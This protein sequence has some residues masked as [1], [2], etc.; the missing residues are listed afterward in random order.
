[1]PIPDFQ[2]IML[3]FLELLQDGKERTVR[4]VTESL[5]VHFR[6]TDEE[7][8]EHLPSGQ[9]LFPNRVAW[10]KTHLKHAGLIDSPAWGKV[11][12]TEEGRKTLAQKPAMVNM[13]MLRQFPAYLEFTGHKANGGEKEGP[14]ET[15]MHSTKTPMEL[16]EASFAS[17]RKATEIELLARL[18]AC[19]PPFFERV[20]VTVL[21]KMGYGGVEEQPV[22]GK[23]KDA[24]I[25]GVGDD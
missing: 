23:S 25:D 24:G 2:S 17:L 7:R 1:M 22:T 16:M 13:K 6:L 11:S 20:V 18:K 5:A 12:I 14:E 21:R 10:A 8:R 15:T 3:P 4:E 9:P 19:S